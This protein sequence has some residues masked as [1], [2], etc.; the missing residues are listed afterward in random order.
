MIKIALTVG[1]INGVGPEVILKALNNHKFP[2]D[3]E[4][5]IIGPKFVLD[6]VNSELNYNDISVKI[7]EPN[8]DLSSILFNYGVPTEISGEIAYKSLVKAI[9][10]ANNNEIDGIVTA[11]ISKK[12]LQMAG[13]NFT[14]H[15]EILQKA[16]PDYN[17]QMLF[18]SKD[19][20]LLIL[21][22]HIPLNEVSG[23]ITKEL[24]FDNIF[25]LKKNLQNDFDII[26]PKFT[27]SGLNP[28]AGESGMLGK[29]EIE[30]I[31]PAI[32]QL[33]ENGIFIDGPFP[34]D[35]QW[36]TVSNYDCIVALYHD[37]GLI[38]IKL[39]CK[40]E[41]VNVTIGLPIVRTSPCHGTA[42]D[43]AGKLVASEMSITHSILMARYIAI[44]RLKGE[45]C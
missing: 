29:E 8:V 35:S 39:L 17:A 13:Y 20:K 1:D 15:T 33:K 22:R 6:K 28:H 44:N 40:D 25:Q 12:A 30:V 43:I 18:A 32:N 26:N 11:P 31:V 23:A 38:P 5:R 37:Q 3:L 9:E 19:Y 7:V 45:L 4:I 27:I 14:G 16:Y 2:E 24:I 41:L 34:P 10:L 21:T 36:K 42:Y